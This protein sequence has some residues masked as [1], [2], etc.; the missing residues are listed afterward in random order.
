V[1]EE[2]EAHHPQPGRAQVRHQAVELPMRHG[3]AMHQNYGSCLVL[4]FVDK[5]S[6]A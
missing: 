5:V 4:A 2:I 6:Q 1:T 3:R